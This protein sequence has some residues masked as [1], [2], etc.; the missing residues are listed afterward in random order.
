M[1][2]SPYT[3]P[4]ERTC[5]PK[6]ED[7]AFREKFRQSI[8]VRHSAFKTPAEVQPAGITEA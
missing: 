6:G 7:N 2:N 4:A 8:P 1:V 5:L 3:F